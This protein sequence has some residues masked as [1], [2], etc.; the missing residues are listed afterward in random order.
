MGVIGSSSCGAAVAAAM[1]LFVAGCA[2]SNAAPTYYA[3]GSER[4]GVSAIPAARDATTAAS[5]APAAIADSSSS[6]DKGAD[7]TSGSRGAY[8][9][10]STGTSSTI[11]SPNVGVDAHVGISNADIN[12][13]ENGGSES[14]RH[15]SDED[16][17]P[18]SR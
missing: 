2:S 3:A 11:D 18:T 14:R 12:A 16:E 5:P 17:G 1:A 15:A 7:A 6:S 4:V 10:D 8:A 13:T 9:L